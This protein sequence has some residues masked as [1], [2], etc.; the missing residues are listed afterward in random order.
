MAGEDATSSTGADDYGRSI[1]NDF[2]SFLKVALR[3]Y[4]DRGWTT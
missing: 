2:D 4:Y 1:Y 3:E